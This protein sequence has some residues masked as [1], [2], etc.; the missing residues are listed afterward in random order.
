MSHHKTGSNA[1]DQGRA[2]LAGSA[3]PSPNLTQPSL[4]SSRVGL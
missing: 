1:L 3:R 4:V 2:G